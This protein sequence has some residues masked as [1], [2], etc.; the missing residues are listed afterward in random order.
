MI[1]ELP[2]LISFN[3][4]GDWVKYLAV[5][6]SSFRNDFIDNK[7]FFN[8]KI[9]QVRK[10][11][12]FQ[13][14]EK[15]F[16][17]IISEGGIEGARTPDMQRCARIKWPKHIID[18]YEHEDVLYW[19]NTRRKNGTTARCACFCVGDW[20]YLVILEIRDRYVLLISAYPLTYDHAKKK[21][22]KEYNEY[23]ENR[24]RPL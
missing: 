11:P 16:W 21:C 17:H 5:I 1:F 19:E 13:E 3:D 18:S 14:K 20:E 2:G 24:K 23:H 15:T 12:M 22:Q 9:V 7:T 8:R 10:E 4:Y 6:Y